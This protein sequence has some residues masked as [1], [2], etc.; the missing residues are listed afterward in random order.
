M[1]C[2]K[3]CLPFNLT[4]CWGNIFINNFLNLYKS[5][6]L[7]RMIID[8][9]SWIIIWNFKQTVDVRTRKKDIYFIK[10]INQIIK[11]NEERYHRSK[12]S[13][14]KCDST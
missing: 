9:V 13:K 1:I 11:E 8:I 4:D 5:L 6:L 7:F 3:F 10:N 12:S 2:I 14:I